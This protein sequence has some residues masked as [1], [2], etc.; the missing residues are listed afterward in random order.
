[1][2]HAVKDDRTRDEHYKLN[3]VIKHID[4]PF[5]T[6]YYPLNGYN[7]R[8]SVRSLTERQ[9]IRMGG[10][11]K[12][13]LDSYQVDMSEGFKTGPMNHEKTLQDLVEQYKS[14]VTLDIKSRD[15]FEKVKNTILNQGDNASIK[16]K[17]DAIEFWLDSKNKELLDKEYNGDFKSVAQKYDLDKDDFKVLRGYIKAYDKDFNDFLSGDFTKVDDNIAK[18]IMLIRSLINDSAKKMPLYEG[19]LTRGMTLT[20]EQISEYKVGSDV[21]INS[22]FSILEDNVNISSKNNVLLTI[23]SKNGRLINEISGSNAK[24]VLLLSP[25]KFIVA[26]KTK[27]DDKVHIVLIEV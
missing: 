20:S 9:M 7:C 24:E 8:C 14:S 12:D 15:A 16:A 23:K 26:S 11:S 18:N 4:D 25:S 3:G 21:T 17:H 13:L 1:M 19:T 5:W 6:V 27:V 2:Y 22:F 10:E